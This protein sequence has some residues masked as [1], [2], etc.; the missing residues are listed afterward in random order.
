MVS[1]VLILREDSQVYTLLSWITYHLNLSEFYVNILT[2]LLFCLMF[3]PVV[4]AIEGATA[5][6]SVILAKTYDAATSNIQLQDYWVSEKLDGVRGY[7]DGKNFIS[8]KGNKFNAPGWFVNVLPKIPLDGELWLGRGQFEKLSGIVRR[9]FPVDS[10]WKDVKFMVFDYPSSSNAFDERLRQLQ[11]MILAIDV[12]HVQLVKQFK[13]SSQS[14][15]MEK[16]DEVVSQGGEGLMLYLGSSVYKSGRTSDLLK[17]KKYEDAEAVVIAHMPGQGKYLGMLGALLVEV[18]D[19]KRFKIG[20]GFSDE[21]R[22]N[23]PAIGELVTYKY[24]GLTSKG[25]PR[26]ASF[27]RIRKKH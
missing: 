6:P 12:P 11:G 10:D 7:W 16:L 25:L 2:A 17:V 13:V 24:Y 9:K 5:P 8:R 3:S 23:P 19:K 26:F 4:S 15:L 20:T 27:M 14:Q 21:E 1:L 22:K 18:S